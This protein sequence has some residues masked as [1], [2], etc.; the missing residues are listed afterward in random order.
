MLDFDVDTIRK[1]RIELLDC[2]IDLILKSLEMYSYMYK[3]IYPR[4]KDSLTLEENLR[5]SLVTGTYEQIANQFGISKKNNIIQSIDNSI[6][7][8]SKQKNNKKIS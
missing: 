8:K 7:I 4:T 3:F 2:Q 5:V 1:N 6:K